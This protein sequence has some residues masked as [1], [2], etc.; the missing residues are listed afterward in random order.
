MRFPLSRVVRSATLL[1]GLAAFASGRTLPEDVTVKLFVRPV[2]AVAGPR[3][4]VLVRLPMV[5]LNDIQFPSRGSGF[6][7]FSRVDQVLPG[8][9][10]YW[11]ANSLEVFEGDA[12][13]PR[14]EVSATRLSTFS[15]AS[16]RSFDDALARLK[17]PALTDTTDSF[18]T[19]LWFDVLFEY[20]IRS[21]GSAFSV[22]P[23]FAHL[24]VRVATSMTF[25]E[26][27]GAPR[28]FEFSGDPGVIRLE[29]TGSQVSAE[30]FRSGFLHF[31]QGSDY[32][33]FLLCVIL[34]FRRFAGALLPVAA[35]AL[36]S[37]VGFG[38]VLLNQVPDGFWFPPFVQTLIAGIIILTAIENIA[39]TVPA[40]RRSVVALVAGLVFG[41]DF[42]LGWQA[43]SQFAGHFPLAS[44]VAFCAGILACMVAATVVM[45]PVLR[46]LLSFTPAARTEITVL[47]VLAAHTAWHWMTER[48]ALYSRYPVHFPQVD[49]SLIAAAMR[50]AM[51]LVLLAGA[52]WFFSGYLKPKDAGG[53]S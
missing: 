42:A 19:Q 21:A 34:P 29:P 6:I 9:A 49:A 3:L 51:V 33:L 41:F 25:V 5:A 13:L 26:P 15:D 52:G 46:L 20:P 17:G 27:Q 12:R 2:T 53:Q 44:E 14:P 8:A 24:G 48:F 38:A 40:S 7:D 16:F 37:A 1:A 36:S 18:L 31:L 32:L 22:S 35:L 39:G 11:V 30:F 45:L 43:K 28:G 4:Q 23:K 50:W 47:S 10:R